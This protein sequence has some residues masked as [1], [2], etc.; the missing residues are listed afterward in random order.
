MKKVQSSHKVR[1]I[2]FLLV[3][4]WITKI[5]FG[6]INNY[7]GA[8][9][10]DNY[11][12]TDYKAG[13]ANHAIAQDKN[14]ILYFANKEGLL[15]YDG[16]TWELFKVKHNL[17]LLS[18]LVEEEKIYVGSQGE[19]GYFENDETGELEYYSLSNK[20]EEDYSFGEIIG[21][22]LANSLIYFFSNTYAFILDDE[23]I[24]VFELPKGSSAV[25]MKDGLAISTDK[26]GLSIL[27]N[28]GFTMLSIDGQLNRLVEIITPQTLITSS[29]ASLD[30]PLAFNTAISA[31]VSSLGLSVN[32]LIRPNA[33]FI[34]SLIFAVS[35]LSITC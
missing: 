15:K 13:T 19:F 17:Y 1:Y 7:K 12:K 25:E 32:F 29:M 11:S 5:S 34:L 35:M 6:Q 3:L 9:F 4:F 16:T 14:G 33:A 27:D 28:N 22:H 8:P 24:S 10:I 30:K 31:F 2:S 21:I 26:V 23:S 20:L 18:A